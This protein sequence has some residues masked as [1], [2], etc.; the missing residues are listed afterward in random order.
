MTPRILLVQDE[1]KEPGFLLLKP[2][3]AMDVATP[4]LAGPFRG[5]VYAPF[6]GS[7]TLAGLSP[8]Q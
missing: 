6:V 7:R 5:W 8:A 2:V 4:E 1:N 3:Y